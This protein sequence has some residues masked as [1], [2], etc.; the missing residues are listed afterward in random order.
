MSQ[1]VPDSTVTF[2]NAPDVDTKSGRT[3]IFPTAAAREA[4]FA[5]KVIQGATNVNCTVVKKRFQTIKVST[6]LAT[7]QNANYMSF[8][9]PSY[10]NKTYY[11]H[12]ESTDYL[13]NN[14]TLVSFS[15]DHWLTEM[16]NIIFDPA[17]SILREGLT[18]SEQS[19]LSVNPYADVIK[20]RTNE[21]LACN[22]ETEPLH[23]VIKGNQSPSSGQYVNADGWN[24][25][26]APADCSGRTYPQE[27]TTPFYIISFTECLP[28][29]M[30]EVYNVEYGV[31]N[32]KCAPYKNYDWYTGEHSGATS[33]HGFN[34][35]AIASHVPVGGGT[36]KNSYSSQ[37]LHDTTMARPYFMIGT[38]SLS[39]ISDALDKFNAYDATSAVLSVQAMPMFLLDEFIACAF[40]TPASEL[41]NIN[42]V[43]IPFPTRYHGTGSTHV[44]IS[45]KLYRFP[46][47]YASLDGVN[48]TGHI[49][50]QYEKMGAYDPTTDNLSVTYPPMSPRLNQGHPDYFVIRKMVSIT[51]DGIYIGA[52][53]VDYEVRLMESDGKWNIANTPYFESTGA[54][55]TK[56]SK[57]VFYND[58]PMVPY[59]TDSFMAWLSQQA[60][61]ATINNTE[62]N[63]LCEENQYGEM[64]VAKDMAIYNAVTGAVGNAVGAASSGNFGDAASAGL[65]FLTAGLNASQTSNQITHRQTEMEQA[66]MIANGGG[67]YLTNPQAN[68]AFT[69]NF[70]RAK[71][72]FVAPNY[73]QGSAGGVTNML[74]DAEQIGVTLLMHRRSDVLADQ[75]TKFFKLYGYA[76][77]SMRVPA[78]AK[79]LANQPNDGA[80]PYFENIG[81][82]GETVFY[83]Q[84]E[85]IH[86]SGLNG[87]A[88]AYI[89]NMFNG[90]VLFTKFA[91]T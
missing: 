69:R 10:G 32:L 72:A 22:D 75:Y 82:T 20:M 81:V 19:T 7:I 44:D 1:Y 50:L 78:V 3:A 86:L 61:S 73:H 4:F 12:I 21:P 36:L 45:P 40:D 39:A 80:A 88:E 31:V 2:Y 8:K 30:W 34:Y 48:D 71:G 11:C 47:S 14:V 84:T 28:N 64:A 15:V 37:P 70:E 27:A 53:P 17:T 41:A 43:K 76:D 87:D 65:G 18:I 62:Y 57:A 24:L 60:K 59:V 35:Y 63:R 67:E 25:F 85:N 54:L 89:S 68:N 77:Q 13:N 42:Y 6:P 91:T 55:K 23:Y 38:Q 58:F 90:G 74:H 83:T 79:F 5:T 29:L 51:A 16:F 52:G 33:G 56:L 9:N 49:E 26:A 46:F 66:R